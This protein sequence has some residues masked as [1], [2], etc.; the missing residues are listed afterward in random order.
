MDD[1]G[2][3]PS[4]TR[5]WCKSKEQVWIFFLNS[6]D[7]HPSPA[8]VPKP[9]RSS[10]Y[11][12]LADVRLKIRHTHTREVLIRTRDN[13][14]NARRR[15]RSPHK[16]RRWHIEGKFLF[17]KWNVRQLWPPRALLSCYAARVHAHA[18][19]H[20]RIVGTEGARARGKSRRRHESLASATA[21]GNCRAHAY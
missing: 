4:A 21:R 17:E 12:F 11:Y 5:G 18:H 7:S 14:E 1:K 16:R 3:N 10:S 8:T 9:I 2:R 6:F 19:T 13:L 20:T 15:R